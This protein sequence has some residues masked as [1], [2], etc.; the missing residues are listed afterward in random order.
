MIG[1]QD[2][3]SNPELNGKNLA[4]LRRKESRYRNKCKEQIL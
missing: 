2:R 1:R 3:R 4:W